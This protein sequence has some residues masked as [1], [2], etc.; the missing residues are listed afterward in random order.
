MSAAS[1]SSD[2][3]R[4]IVGALYDSLLLI[5]APILFLL[6][7]SVVVLTKSE[8]I[9]F[10][11]RERSISFWPCFAMTFTMAH[12]VAVFF[13]SH[14]RPEIFKLYPIRFIVVPLVLFFLFWFSHLAMVIGLVFATWFDNWHSSLQTFGIGRLYDMRAKNDALTGRR[15][16]M[17]LAFVTFLGPILAGAGLLP[18]LENFKRFDATSLYALAKVPGWFETHHAYMAWPVLIFCIGYVLFYLWSYWRLAQSGYRVS[19]QK[20][21][22]WVI[23]SLTS[24]FMWGF[25][26]LGQA[27]LVMESFHSLQYFALLWWSEKSHLAKLTRSENT[28]RQGASPLL[29]LIGLPLAFGLWVSLGTPAPVEVAIFLVVEL[30]HY[31][32]D[33]FIWSVRKKMVR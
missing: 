4:W 31:W 29:L 3:S 5:G 17:G 26:S 30:M 8:D 10:T 25:D 16:D 15:L 9:A 19:K 18:S 12:L 13:R 33:G 14:A 7:A 21:V 1:K 24:I 2:E 32:Y 22:L 6:L 28:W 27:F 23:L 20:V 11:F